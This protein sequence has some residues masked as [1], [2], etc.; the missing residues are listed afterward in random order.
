MRCFCGAG[1]DIGDGDVGNAVGVVSKFSEGT[2]GALLGLRSVGE[3]G[4]GLYVLN[5]S[6]FL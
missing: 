4:V 3:M 6:I 5:S 2:K 1:E